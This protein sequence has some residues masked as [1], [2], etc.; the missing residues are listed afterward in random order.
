MEQQKPNKCK[1]DIK[2]R[3]RKIVL[4]MSGYCDGTDQNKIIDREIEFPD[5][6]RME[7]LWT[8]D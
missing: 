1:I 3:G 5:F 2:K 4:K 8:L 6:D 7:D